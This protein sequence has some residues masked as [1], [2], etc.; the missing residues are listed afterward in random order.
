MESSL[1]IYD[2]WESPIGKLGFASTHYGLCRVRV[3]ADETKFVNELKQ[4]YC[5][6]PIRSAAF[7]NLLQKKF[8]DYFNHKTKQISCPLD[9]RGA[10]P[11][12][13]KVWRKMVDIPYGETRSYRWLAEQ[14]GQ[15]SAYR[16]V[17]QASSANP[18]PIIIPCHR[19]IKTNGQLGGYTAGPHTKI[20]LL[21]QEGLQIR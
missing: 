3:A 14:I 7:F 6:K 15:P 18:L 21:K 16:A 13:L 10:T 9:L 2:I 11:F 8:T 20:T 5:C 12:Q 1:L 4:Q 17:G 19:V